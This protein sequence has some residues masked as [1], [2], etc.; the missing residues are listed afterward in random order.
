MSA[1]AL[2]AREASII[3]YVR[4]LA[5]AGISP[6]YRD[7]AANTGLN[8]G[9]AYKLVRGLTEAR[10]LEHTA[11]KH[12]SIRPVGHIDLRAVPAGQLRAELARRG[13]TLDA[14]RTGPI[15]TGR[16]ARRQSGICAADTCGAVVPFGH[17]MCR[18]HWFALPQTLQ[19]QLKRAHAQACRTNSNVDIARYQRLLTKARDVADGCGGGL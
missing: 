13:E 16:S 11:G 12:R 7:I 2:S 17:L 4:E 5:D 14:M 3:R 1:P 6:S 19:E 15:A 18:T 9:A 8:V 10:H